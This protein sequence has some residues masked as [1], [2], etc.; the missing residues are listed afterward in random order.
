MNRTVTV[1][2]VNIQG[3]ILFEDLLLDE[4]YHT[5]VS[6]V[7]G[8]DTEL[9]FVTKNND[10]NNTIIG[11]FVTTQKSNL[12][13]KHTPGTDDFDAIVLENG[14]G[15]AYVNI[16]L[17]DVNTKTLF[18]EQNRNGVNDQRISEFFMLHSEV[19]KISNFN[20]ELV[21]VLKESAYERVENLLSVQTI[22]LNI[23]NPVLMAERNRSK[24]GP[25]SGIGNIAEE[26]NA[27][28]SIYLKLSGDI[29]HGGMNKQKT[30]AFIE[31]AMSWMR[32]SGKKN[33]KLIVRGERK[34]SDG[35]EVR[36]VKETINLFL[37]RITDRFV[38]PEN[39]P[40]SLQ[41]QERKKGILKV[42]K[43]HISTI[44]GLFGS[45]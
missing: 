31:K 33:P 34:D 2:R 13:P 40:S 1:Y 41:F 24:E 12:P 5:P 21:D 29:K 43:N 17:Y 39:E 7:N 25:L 42:Y 16:M 20:I 8:R 32:F 10:P 44:K 14:E 22:E 3:E 28:K 6:I 37:D 35:D 30:V 36:I 19:L 9:K 11:L 27:T 38:L 45:I 23:A 15:L 4:A 26:M 18:L